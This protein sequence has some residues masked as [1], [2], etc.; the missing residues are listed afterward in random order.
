M[1]ERCIM[2]AMNIHIRALNRLSVSILIIALLFLTLSCSTYNKATT[3]WSSL[4][5]SEQAAKIDQLML[6]TLSSF[7]DSIQ[8]LY[9]L[10]KQS[11]N[12]QGLAYIHN[13]ISPIVSKTEKA[14][15]TYHYLVTSWMST[16]TKPTDIDV[17]LQLAK[18]ALEELE[19]VIL[20]IAIG[21]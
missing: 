1:E 20:N 5:S 11:N 7:K 21:A 18:L 12:E 9:D 19:K 10:Y 2:I 4:S 17:K 3:Q 15:S 14:I 13:Q 8:Q 16:G 6:Q